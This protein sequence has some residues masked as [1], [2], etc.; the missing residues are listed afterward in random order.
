MLLTKKESSVTAHAIL[1][2]PLAGGHQ[3]ISGHNRTTAA[4]RAGLQQIPAWVR[5]MDD[6]AAFM[7]LVLSNAQAELSPLERGM[8]ALEATEK[9]KHNGRSIEKYSLAVGRD[10]NAVK[11]EIYAAEVYQI[12]PFGT[13]SAPDLVARTR[14]LCEIHAA[15]ETSWSAMVMGLFDNKWSIEQTNA[16]VK[17]VN[18]VKPPRGSEKL[19]A[20]E[21]L[22]EVAA[23][24]QD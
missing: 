11:R 16:A 5:E 7:Q 4:R 18:A 21:K 15:P 9:G 1:V 24:G 13:I 23:A 12:A 10:V 22:Q 17:A 19:F 6:D 8:H 3:I 20:I 14:H 2:R